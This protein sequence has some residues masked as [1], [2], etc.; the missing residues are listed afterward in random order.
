MRWLWWLAPALTVGAASLWWTTNSAGQ[1]TAAASSS[2]TG[3][4]AAA[5]PFGSAVPP[6]SPG[7]P[8]PAAASAPISRVPYAADA[9]ANRQA[10]LALWRQRLARAEASLTAYRQATRY[11]H[12]SQPLAEHADQAYP[13]QPITEDK[14]FVAAGST[15]AADGVHLRTSQERVFV[16]GAE[17]VRFT[18]SLVDDSGRPAPLHV[19]RADAREV[20]PPGRSPSFPEVPLA[21]ADG[22][23]NGDLVAGDGVYTATLQPATQGFAGLLGQIRVEAFLQHQASGGVAQPGYVF[24]DIVYTPDAP[25]S[26]QGPVTEALDAGSLNFYLPVDVHEPGRYVV[27]GRVDDANGKPVALLTFNDDV[28]AGRQAFK[29]SLF[30]KLVRDLKPAF[31]LVLRDVDAFRL[32]PDA[33]PDRSL[34]ARRP[35]PVHTSG[36]YV[37]DSF[38]D[39]DWTSDE[40]QRYLDELGKDV[41]DARTR[42]GQLG[43]GP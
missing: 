7:E 1:A 19:L 26:W 37:L 13:N 17:S 10:Q 18:L 11:P 3:A 28:A 42:V 39:A 6:G 40:R 21:F 30:G 33:F 9:A 36:K 29:L 12:G 35:G 32:R 14:A 24:F 31:P 8:A 2:G 23:S 27:T 5:T 41:D 22:G 25:A 16:Q 4:M 15:Q 43:T 34:M 38:A 20:T